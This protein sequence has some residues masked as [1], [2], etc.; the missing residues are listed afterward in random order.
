M[1][2]IRSGFVALELEYAFAKQMRKARSK[3]AP[4]QEAVA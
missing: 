1:Q 3:A 2:G 4:P